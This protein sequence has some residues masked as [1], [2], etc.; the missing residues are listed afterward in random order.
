MEAA[1]LQIMNVAVINAALKTSAALMNV[2]TVDVIATF[3]AV[4][5]IM[6]GAA[7]RQP[8]HSDALMQNANLTHAVE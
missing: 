8:V 1:V 4:I 6:M 2:P 7:K 3:Y 5:L